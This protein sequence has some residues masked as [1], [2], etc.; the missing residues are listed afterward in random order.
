VIQRDHA[1]SDTHLDSIVSPTLFSVRTNRR[2]FRGM[3]HLTET[4]SWQWAFQTIAAN[5]RW[6]LPDEDVERHMALAFEF[7]M[8]LL[9]ER[10]AATRRLD[11]SGEQPLLLAKR[12]RREALSQGGRQEPE[13]VLEAAE[14]HFGLPR[15]ALE[16]WRA[17]RAQR[18]W[19]ARLVGEP[20][21]ASPP[22]PNPSS[23]S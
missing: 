22:S 14:A 13:R 3:V 10:D 17:S 9:G 19:R 2:L 20:A 1:E 8:E 7:V 21:E 18:P 12:M 15:T 4:Q 11:P 16:F 5:S 23:D 6:D